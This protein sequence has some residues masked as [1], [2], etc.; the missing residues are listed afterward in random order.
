LSFSFP[1]AVHGQTMLEQVLWPL[2]GDGIEFWVEGAC[3]NLE[4]C[5]ISGLLFS[6]TQ[7]KSIMNGCQL[8]TECPILHAK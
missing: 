4:Q 5:D 3:A 6:A 7:E 8:S 2:C 1:H